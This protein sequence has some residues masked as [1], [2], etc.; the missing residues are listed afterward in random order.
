LISGEYIKS[1]VPS[2][3]FFSGV[4]LE[5]TGASFIGCR[6]LLGASSFRLGGRMVVVVVV[7][8][9]LSCDSHLPPVYVHVRLVHINALRSRR[10]GW[11]VVW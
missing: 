11:Y 9:H 3:T 4:G 10:C 1:M 8:S 5:M 7:D 2:G 6:F